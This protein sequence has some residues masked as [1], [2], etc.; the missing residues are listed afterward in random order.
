MYCICTHTLTHS[1]ISIHSHTAEI[2]AGIERHGIKRRFM[3]VRLAFLE[4][5]KPV[6]RLKALGGVFTK[7]MTSVYELFLPPQSPLSHAYLIHPLMWLPQSY[8]SLRSSHWTVEWDFR[9]RIVVLKKRHNLLKEAPRGPEA[10]L[11]HPSAFPHGAFRSNSIRWGH[12]QGKGYEV[13]WHAMQHFSFLHHV[14]SRVIHKNR[15]A[16][17]EDV[18]MQRSQACIVHCSQYS[19]YR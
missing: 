9:K 15:A 8:H 19:V 4:E 3:W 17:D 1:Q 13:M 16:T 18:S 7:R 11:S 10:L 6:P 12:M 2:Q 14:C 5:S